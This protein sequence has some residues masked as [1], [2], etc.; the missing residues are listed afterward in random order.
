MQTPLAAVE[1]PSLAAQPFF[2]LFS[3][4]I[5]LF[6]V[7]LAGALPVKGSQLIQGIIIAGISVYLFCLLV[8]SLV[9]IVGP[10][11]EMKYSVDSFDWLRFVLYTVVATSLASFFGGWVGKRIFKYMIKNG[12]GI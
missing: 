5:A 6:P 7:G 3:L 11:H 1:H 9:F 4:G 10:G 2:T 8:T 12:V